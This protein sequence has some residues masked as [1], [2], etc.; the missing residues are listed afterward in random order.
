MNIKVK[1]NGQ[2][3][4]LC[5]GKLI[6]YIDEKEYTFPSYCL[7]SGGQAWTNDDYTG[8]TQGNWSITEWPDNFPEDMKRYVEFEVNEQIE[9][10]CCGGCI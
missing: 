5:S 1:Y 4:N 7:S 9:K 3:P 10:G 2:Y 8:T 6:V